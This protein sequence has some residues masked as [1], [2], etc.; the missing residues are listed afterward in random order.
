[1]TINSCFQTCVIACVATRGQPKPTVL[2]LKIKPAGITKHHDC[3]RINHVSSDVSVFR[4]DKVTVHF[5]NRDG[6]KLTV[7]GSPGESLLDVVINEDLDIDG[8]GMYTH[9][10]LE[11]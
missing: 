10:L 1:M 11:V 8:F 2:N 9:S 3:F 6:E 7:K 5:I 4:S